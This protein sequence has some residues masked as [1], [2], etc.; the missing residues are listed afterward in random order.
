MDVGVIYPTLIEFINSNCRSAHLNH[1]DFEVLYVRKSKRC[2]GGGLEE[3]FDIAR[4]QALA[5]GSGAFPRLLQE[6]WIHRP[7]VTIYVESVLTARFSGWLIRNDFELHPHDVYSF[8]KRAP[9]I[10]S[11]ERTPV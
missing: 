5:P 1:P 9:S 2:L 3:T 4:V 11:V 10:M 8:Y 7:D 6:I